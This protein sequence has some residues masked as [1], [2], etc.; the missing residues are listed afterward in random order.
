MAVVFRG[1]DHRVQRP[2]AIKMLRQLERADRCSVSRFQ[3]EA[4]AV[5]MLNH[6]N[7]VRAYDFF[8]D[9]GCSYLVM[10]LV[11]GI[12]LKQWLRRH[13]PLP[14]L[15]AV[16]I[17]EQV[18]A[19][20]ATAH[21]HGFI[22]RDIKPQNILLD[23]TGIIKVA[24]FGIVH[25]TR[26]HTITSDGTVLGTADYIAPE[27]ARGDELAP[28]TDVYSLGVVLY[29]M[30]TGRVPFTGP[31]P[32]AVASQHATEPIPPPSRVLPSISP[33]VEAVVLRALHK[34]PA[35]RYQSA[36][37]FALALRLA[38]EA[39]AT[40]HTGDPGPPPGHPSGP[41][42]TPAPTDAPALVAATATVRAAARAG[43]AG[44][45]P[46]ASASAVALE[47]GAVED[48]GENWRDVAA[49]L[50]ANASS[51]SPAA[52]NADAA[53]G[54]G[55]LSAS[56]AALAE[57]HVRASWLRLAFVALTSLVLLGGTLGLE[58]WL[59]VHQVGMGLLP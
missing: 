3:R 27:Q 16:E 26:G 15:Q 45:Q 40:A 25:I 32:M 8:E 7:V 36:T 30:L 14:Q 1:W 53:P 56:G 41:L 54:A 31:T 39:V 43:T 29:E 23:A 17:A 9:C 28:A 35:R 2:V 42:A 4:H 13:G 50:L 57:P 46:E 5:A 34:Q 49:V 12:N 6:P 11:D 38:R 58:L 52:S 20:L 18:C 33:Y 37:A 19:A 10:E 55:P 59:N 48:T 47:H 44:A 24:D 21:A 22:H 51:A